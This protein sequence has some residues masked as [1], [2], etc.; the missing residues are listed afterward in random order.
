L[1]ERDDNVPDFEALFGER[2]RAADVL[3]SPLAEAV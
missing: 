2:Q 3:C 1:I